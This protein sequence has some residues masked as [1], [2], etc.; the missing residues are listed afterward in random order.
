M[1]FFIR[2][3]PNWGGSGFLREKVLIEAKQQGN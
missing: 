2:D 1:A 3:P